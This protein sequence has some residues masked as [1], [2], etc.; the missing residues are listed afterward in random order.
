MLSNHTLSADAFIGLAVGEGDRAAVETLRDAEHSKHRLLLVDVY[1]AAA[2]VD[3]PTRA[4][5][6]FYAGV[7]LLDQA[8]AT[9]DGAVARLLT[10][11][12]VGS[13]AHDCRDSVNR[14]SAP[15]FGYLAAIAAAAAIPLGLR[16]EI[17]VPVSDGRVLLP[18]LGCLL[19]GDQG[20]WIELSS[21]G[22]R[23]RAGGVDIACASLVPDDGS[24]EPASPWQGTPL[25]RAEADGQ[26]WEVLLETSDA[27]LDCYKLPML[28]AMRPAEVARWR[29]LIQAAWELLVHHHA[30][31]AG[32]IADGVAVIVPLV[33]Q[34][35]LDSAASPVAF[36]AIATS[37]PPSPVSL[38]EVLI[39][40]FQHV[41]LG[42]LMDLLP[43]VDP[44]DERGYAPWRED[45]RPVGGLLQGVY[46]F[47]GVA[48][49]WDVQRH[50]ETEPDAVLRASV[51]YERWRS[52]IAPVIGA[53]LDAG[54]LTPNGVQFVT[55]LRERGPRGDGGL[56]S[57][58]AIEIARAVALDNWL[59]WQLRHVAVDTAGLDRLAGAFACGEALGGLALPEARIEDDVRNFDSIARSRVLNMRFQEPQRFR[60]LPAGRIGDLGKADALLIE[61]SA[62]AA[63]V[64]YCAEIATES[65]PASWIGL[66]M[67][68]D[69]LTG[70]SRSV[71]ASH[72]PLLF[73]MHARLISQGVHAD[74]LDIASWLE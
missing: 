9:D 59:T 56:A 62:S 44:C 20:E 30:W 49:F 15:D 54:A 5:T 36:G 1:L 22:V 33:K 31:A 21:D 24:V 16:F 12:Y 60:D 40:E 74:P 4:T 43:L 45:P 52:S 70:P 28:T 71:F 58:E 64:A 42:A 35:S 72:L 57:A 47:T 50:V 38:A 3:P 27:H 61:G 18:G 8:R 55:A 46:A 13:W 37:V 53:L 34:S 23:L 41:K 2:E 68:V 67:A 26:V 11:P 69:Q 66:A 63:V 48:H 14:G 65:D 6:A 73:E 7:R 39:H 51:L 17:E 29:R 32:P 10:L 25:A 19:V